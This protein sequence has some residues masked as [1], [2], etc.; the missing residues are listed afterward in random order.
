MA[1]GVLVLSALFSRSNGSNERP[2]V[3][4][5]SRRMK[6]RRAGR[7]HLRTP[8][9]FNEVDDAADLPNQVDL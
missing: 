4:G 3:C 8:W 7:A 6:V 9:R 1:G 5:A 2:P